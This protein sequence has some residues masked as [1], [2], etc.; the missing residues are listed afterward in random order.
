MKGLKELLADRHSERARS[1]RQ[2]AFDVILDTC[3]EDIRH[4]GATIAACLKRFPDLADELRPLLEMAVTLDSVTPS[5]PSFLFRSTT[6][7]RLMNLPEAQGSTVFGATSNA[8]Q[9]GP[10]R[11]I[12]L[13]IASTILLALRVSAAD[14]YNPILPGTPLYTLER[15]AEN[16]QLLF[17]TDRTSAALTHAAFAHRRLEEAQILA[18]CGQTQ[19]AEQ[20]TV[21]YGQQVTLALQSLRS[22][23]QANV[24]PSAAQLSAQLQREQM[25]LNHSRAK[26]S[27]PG[28]TVLDHALALSS[29]ATAQLALVVSFK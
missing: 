29:Q 1:D 14:A 19:L 20:A 2:A 7:R 24:Q 8:V 22:G 21:E 27:G 17:Q 5:R 25:E 23:A 4:N 10:L 16:F 12:A 13:V 6:R 28:L 15:Q 18:T 9:I 3:L 26:I 11:L